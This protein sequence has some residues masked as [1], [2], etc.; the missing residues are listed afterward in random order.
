MIT[1]RLTYCPDCPDILSLIRDIDCKLLGMSNDL[2]NNTVLALNRKINSDIIIDL[3]NYKR[4]L[5]YKYCNADYVSIYS[6]VSIASKIKVLTLG[7]KCTNCDEIVVITPTTTALPP[8]TTSTS[9]TAVPT[10]TTTTT[11]I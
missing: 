6:L 7:V 4:I 10:T 8:R 1:P 2:Y 5:L 11:I 9:T 3:I